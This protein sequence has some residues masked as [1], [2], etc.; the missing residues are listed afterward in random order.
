[1]YLDFVA[2]MMMFLYSSILNGLMVCN[3][4][5]LTNETLASVKITGQSLSNVSEFL[6]S[7]R[8]VQ[9]T[10]SCHRIHLRQDK[11]KK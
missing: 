10:A 4:S 8:K 6:T 11:H 9:I 2:T 5:T 7:N 3:S 1:M